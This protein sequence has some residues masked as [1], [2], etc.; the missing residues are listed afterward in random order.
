MN[1]AMISSFSKSLD[2]TGASRARSARFYNLVL[3]AVA[4]S[5]GVA[6]WGFQHALTENTTQ[7]VEAFRADNARALAAGDLPVITSRLS[8]LMSSVN[9]MCI[10]AEQDHHAF[11]EQYRGACTA[12]FFQRRF[13]LSVPENTGVKISITLR[14][15]RPLEESFAAELCLHLLCL[16]LIYWG[17]KMAEEERHLDETRREEERHQDEVKRAEMLAGLASQVAHDIRSPLAALEIAAG[18]VSQLPEKKRLLIRSAV[19]RIR[20]IANSLLDRQTSMATETKAPRGDAPTPSET[21]SPQ[22][23]SSLIESLVSEKRMQ[24]RS[25]SNVVIET[26]LDASSYGLFAEI[27]PIEFKRLLSN[28]VNNSVEAFGLGPGMVR[29]NLTARDGRALVSLEDDGKGIPADVLARL[30]QRGETHGKESGSGLGLYHARISAESWGGSLEI[31]SELGKGTR[32]IVNLPQAAPPTWFVPEL[33]LFSGQAVV[34]LDDDES[35][36]QVWQGRLDLLRAS[37]HCVE[38]VHVSTPGEIRTWVKGAEKQAHGALYLLDYELLGYRETGLSLAEE[39]RI[40]GRAVLVTSRYEEGV[41]LEGCRKLKM[42]MIPKG[43]AG[44]VP[45]RIAEELAHDAERRRKLL[46]DW[47]AILVDDDPLV[48]ETWEVAADL[49]HKRLKVFPSAEDFF[50]EAA[51][52]GRGTPVYIDATLGNNSRGE[53]ESR[54]IHAMGFSEIYLATGQK[55]EEF[56]AYVHLRGVVG[57]NPPWIIS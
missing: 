48:R 2:G 5:A 33:T 57:K 45:M 9:W 39:L 14:L 43:L 15:P 37:A 42:R 26:Q 12:S 21:S 4:L 3:A 24:F 34:I 40:G 55:A 35:I 46:D 6:I 52:L 54:R 30:G 7:L 11:F 53:D 10:S 19:A 1:R 29:V 36:H 41:V 50:R 38:I 47:D 16:G 27:Q 23:L 51:S 44:F 18:D 56:S 28:L 32:A 8:S 31:A 20:D 22:L 17:T 49:A 25:R 13:S